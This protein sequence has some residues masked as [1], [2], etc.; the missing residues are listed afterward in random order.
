[1]VR[2]TFT[3]ILALALASWVAALAVSGCWDRREIETLAFVLAAGIDRD[4]T[5]GQV[6]V[7]A[8]VARPGAVSGGVTTGGGNTAGQ[9]AI[10]L[11]VASGRTTY[12]AIRNLARQSPRRL[13]WAHNRWIIFGEAAARDGLLKYIDHFTRDGQTRRRVGVLVAKGSTAADFLQVEFELS[14]VPAEGGIGLVENVTLATSSFIDAD[15]NDFLVRLESEGVEPVAGRVDTIVKAAPEEPPGSLERKVI[16]KSPAALGGAAFKG[17]RF[18][19][20]LSETEARGWNWIAGKARGGIVVVQPPGGEGGLV[21]L[22]LLGGKAEVSPRLKDGKVIIEVKIDAR[23]NIGDL[24]GCPASLDPRSN[25]AVIPV[26][27]G[28]LARAIKNEIT[29]VLTRSQVEFRADIFGFG[30]AVHQ[31]LPKEWQGLKDRWDEEFS[32]LEVMVEVKATILD[33]GRT[34]R[35]TKPG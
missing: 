19:G 10:W 9:K 25:P 34:V 1:M 32:R 20:W 4:E 23:A 21:G 29:Q 7:T 22:A 24:T 26:L 15:L 17:D 13:Y 11:V 16:A 12:E 5:T 18:V 2:G 27:E 28:L 31:S 6:Q 14:K 8:E 35:S 30:A 3:R 33:P